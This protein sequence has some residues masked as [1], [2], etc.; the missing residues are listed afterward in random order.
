MGVLI[1]S[2]FPAIYAGFAGMIGT[3]GAAV[4]GMLAAISA[5]VLLV[6]ACGKADG[7]AAGAGGPKPPPVGGFVFL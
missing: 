2:M 4:E 6:S 7:Q 3:I 1:L 5:A